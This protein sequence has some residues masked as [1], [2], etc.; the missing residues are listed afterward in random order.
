MVRSDAKHRVS[1][2][3]V[4]VLAATLGH[5]RDGRFAASSEPDR[6]KKLSDFSPL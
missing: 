4:E 2:H 3:A 5:L 6:K 1:N